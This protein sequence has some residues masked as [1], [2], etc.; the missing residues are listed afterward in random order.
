MK[1]LN[2]VV[3]L[4]MAKDIRFETSLM[5]IDKAEIWALVDYYGKLDLVRNE[6]LI[7]YNGFKGDGCGYCAV[8]NLR[9]NGL[10]YYLVDKSTVMVAMK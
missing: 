9:V 2:Y 3:S 10:N 5:W 8:C 7:C 1:V 6:T 4:G